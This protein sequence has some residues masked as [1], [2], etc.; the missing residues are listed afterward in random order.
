MNHVSLKKLAYA[1]VI[2][3]ENMEINSEGEK[4]FFLELMGRLEEA[5]VEPSMICHLTILHE[6]WQ[7]EKW[8]PVLERITNDG[9]SDK[10][11]LRIK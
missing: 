2:L 11:K 7:E 10:K 3:G 4:E 1:K 9:R 5:N 8:K 6:M